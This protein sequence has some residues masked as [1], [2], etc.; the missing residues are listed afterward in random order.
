MRGEYTFGESILYVLHIL[1]IHVDDFGC[2]NVLCLMFKVIKSV[3]GL[4]RTRRR[5]TDLYRFETLHAVISPTS[6]VICLQ[7]LRMANEES[8]VPSCLLAQSAQPRRRQ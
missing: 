2:I 8:S 3:C 4:L 1:D 7:L 6:H 5:T